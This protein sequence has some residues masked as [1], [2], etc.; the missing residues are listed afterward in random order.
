LLT[1]QCLS[2]SCLT[3]TPA[4]CQPSNK[5]SPTITWRRI[6]GYAA[7]I[8]FDQRVDTRLQAVADGLGMVSLVRLRLCK[9][10][11]RTVGHAK[12]PQ[13]KGAAG[14]CWKNLDQSKSKKPGTFL[15]VT[16]EADCTCPSRAAETVR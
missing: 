13:A 4:S 16:L 3:A 15:A 8:D 11:I 7:G 9:S 2:K 6:A 5:P 14:T 12:N 1:S 10:R